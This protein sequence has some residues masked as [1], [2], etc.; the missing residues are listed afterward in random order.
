MATTA[1]KP[2]MFIGIKELYYLAPATEKVTPATI[3]AAIKAAGT[4]TKQIVNSHQDTFSYEND[5][6]EIDKYIN[7]LTGE[8]YFQ[9]PKTLGERRIN[10]ALGVY[11]FEDKAALQGGEV[12]TDSKGNVV[13]W[14]APTSPTIINKQFIARVKTGH[15]VV[16]SNGQVMGKVSP[17]QKNLA[18][19][20]TIVAQDSGISGVKSEYWYK[21]E[22]VQ[23]E[24]EK[25]NKPT[26]S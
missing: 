8:V 22:S 14:S 3:A 26:E 15:Y 19:G 4:S 24:L 18:L 16:F 9:D 12:E 5:D 10:C 2:V 17:Q 13:G 25:L 23:A 7:E 11:Q 20:L 1:N 6:M 21:E